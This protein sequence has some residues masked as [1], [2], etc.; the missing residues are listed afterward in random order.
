MEIK[1]KN[2]QMISHKML[3]DNTYATKEQGFF[4]SNW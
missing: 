1:K 2:S 3:Q 4:S